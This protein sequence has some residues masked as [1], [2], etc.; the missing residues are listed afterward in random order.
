MKGEGKQC[1]KSQGSSKIGTY[2]TAHMTVR[3]NEAG[4]VYVEYK[5]TQIK[6]SIELAHLMLPEDIRLKVASK[7]Q[8][9]VEMERIYWTILEILSCLYTST[10]VHVWTHALTHTTVCMHIH[11]VNRHLCRDMEITILSN[12]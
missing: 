3:Q 5:S 1:M 4:M 12:V 2:C 11:L 7:L 9:S 6:K 8:R 10:H